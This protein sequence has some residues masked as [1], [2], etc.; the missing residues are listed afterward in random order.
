MIEDEDLHMISHSSSGG[1]GDAMEQF[2][3]ELG[4]KYINNNK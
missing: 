4:L 1:S 3:H 2:N